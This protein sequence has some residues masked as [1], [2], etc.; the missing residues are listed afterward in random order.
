[1]K[2]EKLGMKEENQDA[3][4]LKKTRNDDASDFSPFYILMTTIQYK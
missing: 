1:M 2:G 4:T 3:G